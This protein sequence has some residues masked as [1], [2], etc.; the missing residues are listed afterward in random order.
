MEQAAVPIWIRDKK[1]GWKRVSLHTVLPLGA[2]GE[3]G[4]CGK[5]ALGS[6][7]A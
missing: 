1:E 2:K 5:S 6:E 4:S 7:P 3:D